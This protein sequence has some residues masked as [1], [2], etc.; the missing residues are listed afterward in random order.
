VALVM[1][2]LRLTPEQA[3]QLLQ[4]NGGHL[5]RVL[6]NATTETQRHREDTEKEE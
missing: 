2:A 5:A 6:K 4:Q 3:W 1:H